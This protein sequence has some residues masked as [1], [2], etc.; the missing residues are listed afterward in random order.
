MKSKEIDSRVEKAFCS[1]K[2]D[3]LDSVLSDS[4]KNTGKLVSFCSVPPKKKPRYSKILQTAAM[5][6]ICFMF[7]GGLGLYSRAYA[8]CSTVNVDMDDSIE[9]M[10]NCREEVIEAK[11][12]G[13]GPCNIELQELK[14]MKAQDAVLKI[15]DTAIENNILDSDENSILISVE[16]KDEENSLDLSQRLNAEIYSSLDAQG[17]KASVMSQLLKDDS[18]SDSALGELNLSPGKMK[19]VGRV[20]ADNPNLNARLL[21]DMSINELNLMIDCSGSCP[22]GLYISGSASMGLYLDENSVRLSASSDL[23]LKDE[24]LSNFEMS[25]GFEE[26]KPV[27]SISFD[28]GIYNYNCIVDALSGELEKHNSDYNKEFEA[29]IEKQDASVRNWIEENKN[30]VSDWSNAIKNGC[31]LSENSYI[32]QFGNLAESVIETVIGIVDLFIS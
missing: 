23:G 9:L 29:F 28:A 24:K 8:V 32:R 5:L 30:T 1:I 3:I 16:G 6:L 25:F 10:L 19:L 12:R 21:A 31:K 13:N 17:F 11:F 22:E 18:V 4:E 7:I 14:G 26:G 20:L 27:Y 2:P 15:A